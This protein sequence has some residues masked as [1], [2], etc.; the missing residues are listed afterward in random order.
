MDYSVVG[1]RCAGRLVVASQRFTATGDLW[2]TSELG[3]VEDAL[4][5]TDVKV[6]NVH[7]SLL[8]YSCNDCFI[9]LT[10]E[11]P[12][13]HA[14]GS[15]LPQSQTCPYDV[16]FVAHLYT[17]PVESIASLLALDHR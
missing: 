9:F 1:L 13:P 10:K 11:Q 2:Q 3:D 6:L 16:F 5:G 15:Y 8:T 17:S 14:Q 4:F 7:A 12:Y